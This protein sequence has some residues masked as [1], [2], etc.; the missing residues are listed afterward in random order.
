MKKNNTLKKKKISIN[1][2]AKSS[3]KPKINYVNKFLC[4]KPYLLPQNIWPKKNSVAS[5]FT[6]K[7]AKIKMV[8]IMLELIR[9]E[10]GL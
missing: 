9:K 10:N 3:P 8:K 5:V 2:P 4:Y 6:Q 1:E 7:E